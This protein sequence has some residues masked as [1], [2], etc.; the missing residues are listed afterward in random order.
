MLTRSL[1]DPGQKGWGAAIASNALFRLVIHVTQPKPDHRFAIRIEHIPVRF[2]RLV[3]VN[4]SLLKLRS[5]YG[6][7]YSPPAPLRR[8]L[9][10]SLRL[11]SRHVS[12]PPAET[13]FRHNHV[14]LRRHDHTQSPSTARSV[15]PLCRDKN[16][17]AAPNSLDHRPHHTTGAPGGASNRP[18]VFG[19]SYNM[20]H[21]QLPVVFLAA[22]P[23]AHSRNPPDDHPPLHRS[24]V[25]PTHSW[26]IPPL[27][28]H[29]HSHTHPPDALTL[30]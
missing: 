15:P 16:H 26:L 5:G 17:I 2:Y 27:R 11:L 22:F 6:H 24:A 30:Q 28:Y 12:T 29:H 18:P 14:A 7:R 4:T 9:H 1:H 3:R 21:R 20:P 23:E 25:G 13:R 8:R 19:T 10:I